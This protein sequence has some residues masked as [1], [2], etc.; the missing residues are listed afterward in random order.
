[1]SLHLED[2]LAC[3]LSF[4]IRH[5]VSGIREAPALCRY[6]ESIRVPGEK[7]SVLDRR[8]GPVA[9]FGDQ[10]FEPFNARREVLSRIVVQGRGG[11]FH[12]APELSGGFSNFH[13]GCSC[14]K[15]AVS[16]GS[17]AGLGDCKLRDD[18]RR[19]VIERTI[20]ACR[21]MSVAIVSIVC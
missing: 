13:R 18:Y 5:A 16:T 15:T 12:A 19:P 17:C 11:R 20:A 14:F 10:P 7:G 21:S 1:M 8:S 3:D 2:G 6:G 9:E 4:L